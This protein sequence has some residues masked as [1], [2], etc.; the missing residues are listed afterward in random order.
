MIGRTHI[1]AGTKIDNLVQIGHNVRVG[2]ACL[3]CS[4]VGVSGSSTIGDNVILAGQVGLSDHITIGENVRVSAQAGVITDI[5]ANTDVMGY[6]ATKA[7]AWK[8]VQVL[9]SKLPEI[10]KRISELEKKIN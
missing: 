4:Q 9:I 2:K 3:L 10:V 5:E 1:G 7:F 8:R 6:P